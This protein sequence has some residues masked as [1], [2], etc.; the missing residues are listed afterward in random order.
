MSVS[1][2]AVRALNF[3]DD[4][5]SAI[6]V[7]NVENYSADGIVVNLST[8]TIYVEGEVDTPIQPWRSAMLRGIKRFASPTTM[9]RCCVISSSPDIATS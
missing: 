3:A 1:T 6:L 2:N 8:E 5:M 9:A 4:H 7:E